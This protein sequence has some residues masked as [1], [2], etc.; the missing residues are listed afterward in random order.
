MCVSY[1]EEGVVGCSEGKGG[2]KTF[3]SV[4]FNAQSV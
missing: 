4:Y 1:H 3:Q 2:S